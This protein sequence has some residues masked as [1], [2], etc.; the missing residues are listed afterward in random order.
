M[1]AEAANGT[2]LDRSVVGAVLVI[3]GGAD[4]GIAGDKSRRCRLLRRQRR[5]KIRSRR[6]TANPATP[7]TTPPTT[8]R[9]STELPPDP[10]PELGM[11]EGGEPVLPEPPAPPTAP[12]V[13]VEEVLDAVDKLWVVEADVDEKAVRE[14]EGVPVEKVLREVTLWLESVDDVK[15]PLLAKDGGDLVE[16]ASVLFVLKVENAGLRTVGRVVVPVLERLGAT[17]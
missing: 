16:V 6:M 3:P 17:K 11:E 1:N 13:A 2:I 10:A 15:E 8:A 5:R 12:P 9:V 7:P 14:L 4:G